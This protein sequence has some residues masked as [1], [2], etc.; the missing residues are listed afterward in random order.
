MKN[1]ETLQT[2]TDENKSSHRKYIIAAGILLLCIIIG[3]A[4]RLAT[5]SP[6]TSESQKASES[7][8]R[9]AAFRLPE[10]V[11][12]NPGDEF[13]NVTSLILGESPYASGPMVLELA[14]I[15]LL[16]KFTNLRTLY[17]R[18][19]IY[20][21]KDKPKWITALAKLGIFDIKKHFAL[22]LSPL[23]KLHNLQNLTINYTVFK[24]V[25]TLA[26][27]VNLKHLDLNGTAFSDLRTIKNLKNL[28]YLNVSQTQVSRLEP[29]RELANLQTLYAYGT[30][31]SD[32][33]P[34]KELR[35]LKSLYLGVP[36]IANLEPIRNLTQLENLDISDSL[37]SSLELIKGLT[38]LRLLSLKKCKNITDEQVEDLKK[39]L[40]NLIIER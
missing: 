2:Q 23:E 5:W 38:K 11:S 20:P 33:E 25:E 28:E 39:A 8:I 14:D 36:A 21:R 18:H 31:I 30:G 12:K 10:N 35:N 16:E 26:G 6:E 40:P 15:K 3:L 17:I 34:L 32:L 37:V 9:S 27:M 7:I 19:I 22:D 24:N 4:F 1:D 13:A 29:I